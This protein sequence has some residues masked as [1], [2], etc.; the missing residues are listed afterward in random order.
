[1]QVI[2]LYAVVTTPK[3]AAVRAHAACDVQPTVVTPVTSAGVAVVTTSPFAP[4]SELPTSH[5]AQT[6]EECCA[7]HYRQPYTTLIPADERWVR[8]HDCQAVASFLTCDLWH[9][10]KIHEAY[11]V[12]SLRYLRKHPRSR[13]YWISSQSD[14]RISSGRK[15]GGHNTT[16]AP[17]LLYV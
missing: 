5:V 11:L 10:Y 8:T 15:C 9:G 13:Q 14:H 2:G 4:G 16:R 17:W 1:M 6:S 7:H 3:R 12:A